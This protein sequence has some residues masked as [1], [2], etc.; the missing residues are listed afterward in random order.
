RYLRNGIIAASVGAASALAAFTVLGR[1]DRSDIAEYYIANGSAITG[2]DNIVNVILV[3]FRALDTM[4]ELVVLGMAGIAIMAVLS[5]VPRRY[6]DPKPDPS[7]ESPVTYVPTPVIELDV[8]GRRAYSALGAVESSTELLGILQ[9]PLVPVV[10]VISA[11][12]FGRGHNQPGG[13]FIAALVAA[14]AVAY[15]YMAKSRAAPVSRPHIPVYLIAGGVLTAVGTGLLGY[16]G[17]QFLQPMSTY[18]LGMKWVSSLIFDLGVYA[19]VLGLVM[20]AFNTL[21]ATVAHEHVTKKPAERREVT[22]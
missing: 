13:G 20:V 21:G 9:K 10:A 19:A 3:E 18:L 17:G 1:R 15:I 8:E 5:T 22:R 6:F 12:R 7:P 11:V 2:G 16:L 14:C 4:G